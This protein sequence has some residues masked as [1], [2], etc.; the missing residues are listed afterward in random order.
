MQIS[1]F[2]WEMRNLA[3]LTHVP[4]AGTYLVLVA[5]FGRAWLPVSAGHGQAT[6]LALQ[7]CSSV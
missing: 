2:A 4:A 6:W 1:G 3:A 7:V 5:A